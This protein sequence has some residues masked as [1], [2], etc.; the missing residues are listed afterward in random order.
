MGS[1]YRRVNHAIPH[2][3]RLDFV[4]FSIEARP[5]SLLDLAWIKR[6]RRSPRNGRQAGSDQ[7]ARHA[8]SAAGR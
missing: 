7:C 5:G 6:G 3:A 8:H 1:L 4:P 2:R